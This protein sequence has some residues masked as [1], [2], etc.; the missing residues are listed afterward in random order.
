MR[1]NNR[2]PAL[3]WVL[4]ILLFAIGIGG[5]I[6]G[7][8]LFV[9][10]NGELMG[11]TT[12]VLEGSPFQ[13]FLIPGIILFLFVGVFPVFTG[14]SL[15]RKPGWHWPDV[16]N[17]VKQYHWAWTASWTAGVIML[18]W[19]IVETVLLGY[20]SFLQPVIAGWGSIIIILTLTPNVRKYYLT[21]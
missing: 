2:R 15:V 13:N 5:L 4:I 9:S 16:I 7:P 6:S 1:E 3:S 14:Y 12:D 17:P 21:P 10:P 11:M 20:I 8:M 18:V 19:I